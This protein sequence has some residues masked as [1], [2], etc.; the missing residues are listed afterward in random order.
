MS[1]RK[2]GDIYNYFDRDDETD[3]GLCMQE[4][5]TESIVVSFNLKIPKFRLEI[6]VFLILVEIVEPQEAS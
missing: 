2:H 6:K 3:R 4:K 5:C 1:K